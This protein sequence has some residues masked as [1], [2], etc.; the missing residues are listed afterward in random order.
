MDSTSTSA[1]TANV[2]AFL[3]SMGV[4]QIII[5]FLAIVIILTI[6]IL[7]TKPSIKLGNNF[8]SF[9]QDKLS[10]KYALGMPHS[11]CIHNVDFCHIVTK[12][13]EL[14]TRMCYIDFKECI[15]RQM[16]YV[17]EKM[18]TVKSLMLNNYSKLLKTKITNVQ[19]IAHE[20]YVTYHRLVESMLHEDIKNVIKQSF[21]ND[22]FD[23]LSTSE[24][25]V[26]IN[27]KFEYIY[28]V[29]SEFMDIWYISGKMNIS[30]EELRQSVLLLKTK[31]FQ[32][33]VDVYEK[34][35]KILEEKEERKKELQDEL[36]SFFEK[37]VGTRRKL[38]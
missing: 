25:E 12:T 21:A 24:F 6:F 13:S 17:D 14:V 32:V 28:Q 7:I 20:D 19:V 18:S 27:D 31:M 26:Y 34:A 36:D 33:C 1:S 10:K 5:G 35:I 15:D 3:T 9:G 2:W 11:S 22:N 4:A 38:S 37:I 8:I 23:Q 30:R 16:T 29:G